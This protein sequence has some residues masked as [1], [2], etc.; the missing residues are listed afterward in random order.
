M[1]KKIVVNIVYLIITDQ[2]LHHDPPV[3]SLY[4]YYDTASCK[5]KLKKNCFIAFLLFTIFI[6][7]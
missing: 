4:L 7:I 6:E 3:H 5:K 2:P 1:M